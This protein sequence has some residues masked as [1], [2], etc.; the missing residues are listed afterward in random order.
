[1]TEI[2]DEINEH[3]PKNADIT[4]SAFEG[5]NIVLYT[6]SKDFFLDNNG[7]IKKIVDII[8]KRVELRPDPS[9]TMDMEKAKDLVEKI[10]PKDAKVTNVI[11]DPQR[12]RMIVEAEKPGIAI[13][14]SGE[15][16][17]E[18]KLKTLWVPLIRRTPTIKSKIIENIR[19]VLYENNDYRKKFLHEIG[20]KIYNAPKQEKDTWVRV[21]FLGGARQVGRSCYL[22]QTQ[23]SKVLLDC[24]IN[25]AVSGD[26]AFPYLDV[27]E[28][29]ISELDAIVVTHS[30]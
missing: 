2:L 13:G 8:K 6:K 18:I 28:F 25:V 12:S 11:F 5:A 30:H 27:P 15:V 10:I 7:I 20:K 22:L 29:N 9:L 3:L 23:K 4:T 26:E 24:G 21:S 16:L 1:M 19:Y 14:K 17:K